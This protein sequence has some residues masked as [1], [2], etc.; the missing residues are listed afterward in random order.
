MWPA[1]IHNDRFKNHALLAIADAEQIYP[2]MMNCSDYLSLS[3]VK[4]NKIKEVC[5]KAALAEGMLHTSQVPLRSTLA[6]TT[7]S[8]FNWGGRLGIAGAV[9]FHATPLRSQ[10][11]DFQT[12]LI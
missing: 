11:T 6:Q 10:R 3:F 5:S 8:L 4:K 9:L 12:V 2:V 1:L 7:A